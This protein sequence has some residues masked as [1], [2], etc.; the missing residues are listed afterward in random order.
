MQSLRQCERCIFAIK[1]TKD[2]LRCLRFEIKTPKSVK[3]EYVY[4]VIARFD[5]F[6]LCGEKGRFFHDKN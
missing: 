5:S 4:C 3:K 2:E 6:N 1:N